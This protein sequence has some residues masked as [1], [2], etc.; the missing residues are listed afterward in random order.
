MLKIRA[1]V[2]LER[3]KMGFAIGAKLLPVHETE[4]VGGDN[5]TALFSQRRHFSYV[6]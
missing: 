5:F 4:R 3:Q 2:I 1:R 6:G